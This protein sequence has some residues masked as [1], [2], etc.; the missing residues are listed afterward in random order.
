MY[1]EGVTEITVLYPG[2][3]DPKRCFAQLNNTDPPNSGI[4]K[5]SA[6]PEGTERKASERRDAVLTET[7]LPEN[8]VHF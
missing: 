8:H 7:T 4:R 2:K 3:S 6:L 1:R 5:I